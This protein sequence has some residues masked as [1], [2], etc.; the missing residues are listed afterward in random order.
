MGNELVAPEVEY[1]VSQQV[2]LEFQIALVERV[3]ALLEAHTSQRAGI[4]FDGSRTQVERRSR[5][6]RAI[7]DAHALPFITRVKALDLGERELDALS[8]I[9]APHLDDSIRTSIANYYGGPARRHVDAA[10]VMELF[11]ESRAEAMSASHY[12]SDG[13]LLHRAGLI[14]PLPVSLPHTGSNLEYELVPT[15]RLLALLDGDEGP[16]RRFRGIGHLVDA[17]PAGHI[18]VVSDDVLEQIA[19]TAAGAEVALAS[20]RGVA[21]LVTGSHGV[22]KLRLLRAVAS[23]NGLARLFVVEAALLPTDPVRLARVLQAL[24]DEA[25]ALTSRLVLRGI[26]HLC[27]SKRSAAVLLGILRGMSAKLWATSDVDP[28]VD[29]A[30]HLST[31]AGFVVPLAHPDLAL[32]HAAWIAELEQAGVIMMESQV[33]D[34]AS[35]YPITRSA[36]ADVV[37]TMLASGEGS[38]ALPRLAES[39]MPGQLARYARRSRNQAR[40]KHLVLAEPTKDQLVELLEAVRNRRDAYDRWGV[41]D[42]HAV[43]RGIVAMFNGP[44]GTGKTMASNVLANELGLPLF[45]I[46]TSNIVD[47][48]VGE[49]EK[50]LARLFDE[51][52]ACRAALLFDE[53]DSLFGKRV[54]A[55][56]ATD[57][58]ANIQINVLLN[59]IEDYDGFVVLTTNMK[60]ALDSAFL[61]RIVYKI[62][63]DLPDVGER[64]ALWR[65]HL[66]NS[67]PQ[68]AIDFDVLAEEFDRASGGDIKNAALRAVLSCHGRAP[69]TQAILMKAMQNELRANG[70]VIAESGG[71]ARGGS[72]A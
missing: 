31:I 18:G 67:I 72:L 16:D 54:D 59:L 66:P 42:R 8:L 5:E 38:T 7:V 47:R 43:G 33:R 28:R 56:D 32:R 65:Y 22:G 69:V 45:R 10:L 50:N 36:L 70:S 53:A 44:P 13:G 24:V 52:S 12:Y 57:R 27:E 2:V 61:R 19:N 15:P 6:I 46:D 48:Y 20:T 64:T 34:L 23:R 37:G 63:F 62:A 55:K 14:E 3:R 1:P 41:A 17:D 21:V 29:D 9:A 49:T 60:G 68:G 11:Y 58:H 40:M 71:R 4:A 51:A 26:E 39:R 35:D 30:A 25:N